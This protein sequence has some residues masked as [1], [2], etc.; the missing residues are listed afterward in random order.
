M[1]RDLSVLGNVLEAARLVAI[2]TGW[3]TVICS[4]EYVSLAEEG[5]RKESWNIYRIDEKRRVEGKSFAK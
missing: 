5:R 4:H 2:F 1:H 3:P